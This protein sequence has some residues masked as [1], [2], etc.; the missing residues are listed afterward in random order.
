[1][2]ELVAARPLPQVQFIVSL[3]LSMMSAMGLLCAAPHFEGLHPWLSETRQRLA[4]A[5]LEELAL[6]LGFPGRFR[7]FTDEVH[8][9]LLADD[10]ALSYDAFV[11]RLRATPEE[12]YLEM[13]KRAVAQ[14]R[15]PPLQPEE[16][17]AFLQDPAALAEYLRQADLRVDL[18]AALS[19][20]KDLAQLKGR[21]I[22]VV[23]RFWREVYQA[24]WAATLPMMRRSTLYH[25]RQRYRL[26]FPDLFMAVTDRLLPETHADL[27]PERVRFVPSCY[28]GP[29]FT[30]V[31]HDEGLTVFYNCR[32]V[33]LARRPTKGPGLF[34]MLKALA[35]ETRLQIVEMLH[36]REMYAQQIVGRL[37]ISQAAV[38]R[39]LRL[40]VSAG[41]LRVRREGGAKFYTVNG[42]TLAYLAASLRALG[43]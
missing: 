35:D 12:T 7:R 13:A 26:A 6:V 30:F 11:E 41:V 42:D 24:E 37:G 4:P 40:M 32:T 15:E 8:V 20:L 23:E 31:R 16:T 25:R 3:P 2:P 27:A 19:L 9:T 18:D 21:F 34:P 28:I 17:R 10:P 1:V 38:S 14:V 22:A 43:E 39:H 33:H 36:G 5:F 29:Y